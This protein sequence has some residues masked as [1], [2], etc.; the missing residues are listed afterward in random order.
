MQNQLETDEINR[1]VGEI[2]N[3][4]LSSKFVREVR[5]E[6][7]TDSVGREALRITIVIVPGAESKIKGDAL[8]DTLAQI[9]DRLRK[10]GEERFPIVE[11]ATTKELKKS[12]AN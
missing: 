11:Y 1:I 12:G 10:E 2:A 9:Q 6:P 7:A 5:T 8:V 4:N 3:A